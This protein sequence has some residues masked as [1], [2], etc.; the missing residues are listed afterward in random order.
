MLDDVIKNIEKEYSLESVKVLNDPIWPVLRLKLLEEL[1]KKNGMGSRSI[2][3]NGS[4]FRHLAKNLFYGFGDLLKIKNA[5]YI[6]FSSSDRRKKFEGLYHDRVIED[7]LVS[8]DNAFEIENPFPSGIHFKRGQIPTRH[9]IGQSIFYVGVNLFERIYGKKIKIENENI[10]K[11][12]LK[13]YNVNLDYRGLTR[14]FLGQYYFMR[15]LLRRLDPKIVFFVYSGSSYGFIKALKEK[16]VP[17][18]E[19]QHGIIN[20]RHLAYNV[21]TNLGTNLFPDYL[22][23]YGN[24]EL[25]IFDESNYFINSDNVVPI[26]YSFLEKYNKKSKEITKFEEQLRKRGFTKLV[27]ISFQE[28][29]EKQLID[30]VNNAIK[31]DER[32]AYIL[33]LRSEKY[34]L[35]TSIH[36][37]I[38]IANKFNIYEGL[39][40]SDFHVTINST[41]A[42]EAFSFGVETILLDIENQASTYYGDKLKGFKS[43]SFVSSPKE[44]AEK[45]NV[46]P[47]VS[48]DEISEEG[49]EFFVTGFRENFI[50]ETKKILEGKK[51]DFVRN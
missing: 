22:F 42:L 46:Q 4:F 45:I 9:I 35:S 8:L 47:F 39:Q 27:A 40:I 30:F 18:V 6:F 5:E 50:H 13:E 20:E 3:I 25:K 15:F 2:Q 7:A 16:R 38:I 36:R 43:V 29:F 10:L 23:T 51:K 24:Q 41:C 33:F 32:I 44:L 49:K 26:G 19:I 34:Q 17:V 28:P 21:N 48:K 14:R 11:D 37:N 31:F 12:I 1:R